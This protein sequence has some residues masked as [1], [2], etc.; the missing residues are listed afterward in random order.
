[1]N[2]PKVLDTYLMMP[3]RG[4]MLDISRHYFDKDFIKKTMSALA[5]F[6]YNVLQLHL[7]DDQGWRFES[8]KFPRLHEVG[9]RRLT[10]QINHSLQTPEFEFRVHEGFLSHADIKEIVDHGK[11]LN[12]D[13]VPEI[14]IP[15]HT[16]ALL[17]AYPQFGVNGE[18][19]E[20]SGQW[21]ISNHLLRP[22]PDTFE[23]L[24]ELFTEVSSVFP[25]QY[26]H[27]GG[28]ESLIDNWLKDP[29]I[30]SFME[31]QKFDTPKEL[32]IYFMREIEVIIDSLGKKMITWDD[33]FAFDP[34]QA[35]QATVMSWR[36]AEISK[37]AMQHGRD[38][39]FS[40]VFPAYFDYSQELS[41]AEPLAIGGPVTLEDVLAFK[42]IDGVLGV[43]C[44]IWTEYI[45]DPTH[46]EYMMWPRAAALAFAAW[47]EG[48][49]FMQYFNERRA[50]LDLL[51]VT[52][53][54][55]EP[56]KR[57]NIADLGIGKYFPGF[58]VASMMQK[59]EESAAS[60]EIAH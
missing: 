60:G 52:I 21:G 20:V 6:D 22:F 29:E 23:F 18:T 58:P 28:D 35:T 41:E 17:A 8:K 48:N 27:V 12:I 54:E 24:R 38:V 47:G 37:T 1:V 33:A 50:G 46:L 59:L 30:V 15:G 16:G 39:I 42:P 14:N 9:S 49:D 13:V 2:L 34:D 43:Q 44:Q 57:K 56:Q 32:F 10:S 53:R 25:S 55:I 4:A 11:S 51:G 31:E 19:V 36:G 5:L 7:T 40:P 3:W 26:I 45:E